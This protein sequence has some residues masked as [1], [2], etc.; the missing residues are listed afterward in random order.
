[1]A[2]WMRYRSREYQGLYSTADPCIAQHNAAQQQWRCWEAIPCAVDGAAW[3]SGVPNQ[4]GY[5]QVDDVNVHM[6]KNHMLAMLLLHSVPVVLSS[7][8]RLSLTSA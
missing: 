2:F 4:A 7:T 1:M 5:Q 8:P 3:V 6:M